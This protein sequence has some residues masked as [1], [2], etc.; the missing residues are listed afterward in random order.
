M[1]RSKKAA[2]AIIN[3]AIAAVMGQEYARL[4]IFTE[5]IRP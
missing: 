2:I 5:R 1:I 3:G 4:M